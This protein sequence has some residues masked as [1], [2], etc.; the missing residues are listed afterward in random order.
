METP[1]PNAKSF[2]YIFILDRSGSM[3]Q[4]VQRLSKVVIPAVAR[5][6]F[7]LSSHDV[8]TLITFDST[9]E[10]ITATVADFESKDIRSRGCTN[11]REVFPEIVRSVSSCPCTH[12]RIVAISDGMI[13]DQEETLKASALVATKLKQSFSISA[14]AVRLFTSYSQPDTRALASILQLNT[15]KP[16][17]IVDVKAE[18]TASGL[19]KMIETIG[20]AVDGMQ[21]TGPVYLLRATTPCLLQ[22]PWAEAKTEVQVNGLT[23]EKAVSMWLTSVPDKL[24]LNGEIVEIRHGDPVTHDTLNFLLEDK[25]NY[26]VDQL[27]IMKVLNSSS[28]PDELG[29][30]VK[31]FQDLE[32]SLPP[33]AD[34]V[35][36]LEDKTL[37]GRSKFM[38]ASLSRRLKSVTT[39]IQ[40]IANDNRVANLNL[41]QQADYL[42]Q[43]GTAVSCGRNSRALARRADASGTN[44]AATMRAEILAMKANLHMLDGIDDSGHQVSFYSQATTLD[45][46]R[47]MVELADD[48]EVFNHLT[49]ADMLRLFNVVGIPAVGPIGD[50]PDPM[51]YRLEKFLLGAHV[52]V[53]D[54]TM[55]LHQGGRLRVP[56]HNEEI[57][58]AVPVFEDRQVQL[59]LQKHAR[60]SLE[61]ISSIGMRR[62]IAEVPKTYPYTICS[63]LWQMVSEL[64]KK[65]KSEIRTKHF[66]HLVLTFEDAIE[67]CFDHLL[68]ILKFDRD[69]HLSYF[70]SHNGITNMIAPILHYVRRSEPLYMARILRALYS[71]ESYQVMRRAVRDG[72]PQARQE[73]LDKILGVDFS[74][75]RVTPLPPLFSRIE[76]KHC[77]EAFVNS[78]ELAKLT[79]LMWFLP[80]ATLLEPF[81]KA[82]IHSENPVQALQAVP[83]MTEK[84]ITMA[85]ELPDSISLEDFLLFNVVEGLLYSDKSARIGRESN[86]PLLPDLGHSGAGMKMIRDYVAS[87]YEDDYNKR[88]KLQAAKEQKILQNELTAMMLSTKS[89][90]EFE[91]CIRSGKQRGCAD[92]RIDRENSPGFAK[93]HDT[94]LTTE[95]QIP[96]R[97]A[98]LYVIYSGRSTIDGAR[99]FN[100]GNLYTS[101]DWKP[102][103]SL[104]LSVGRKKLW[105]KLQEDLRNRG[106][107]YREG[108]ANRHG[109]SNDFKSYFAM[110]C[111]TLE[112]YYKVASEEAWSNYIK[113]HCSCC[114]VSEFLARAQFAQLTS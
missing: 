67:G 11:M 18:A 14:T 42:R 62:M 16:G 61:Y 80:Y 12:V 9:V 110:G 43:A 76:P 108:M 107:V 106:H 3:H 65:G 25:I 30:I 51:T 58:T 71:F 74:S 6:H 44:F 68:P 41:A 33:A 27:R 22:V 96:R 93:L 50:F 97:A 47:C 54:I 89:L 19:E 23:A 95:E 17:S 32:D 24:V 64:D 72:G 114:G 66:E 1:V 13:N 81:F 84:S 26:L 5:R 109:H 102:L 38:K 60:A 113:K 75:D 40:N 52:S 98:K 10:T 53:A 4:N 82:L 59:F 99:L 100:G 87:R 36:L 35:P 7:N 46:I 15:D 111:Q 55:A 28:T 91:D 94:L 39:T 45:G 2:M 78:E 31:Y 8:Y 101:V 85:L 37:Q 29:R 86:K 48:L 57:V 112:Q 77:S 49:A 20:Y 63:G 21:C 56:G 83:K 92:V 34:L 90:S 104:L 88:L 105:D 79:K 103:Q 69:P 70:L 73:T